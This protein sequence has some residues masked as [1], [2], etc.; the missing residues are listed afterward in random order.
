[1]KYIRNKGVEQG[2]MCLIEDLLQYHLAIGHSPPRF[3][4][5]ILI[6][7]V[8]IQAGILHDF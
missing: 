2:F 8:L 6:I 3:P 5:N 1:M 4:Q 7:K